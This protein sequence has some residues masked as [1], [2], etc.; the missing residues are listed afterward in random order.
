LG[1]NPVYSF[2]S[3]PLQ[4]TYIGNPGKEISAALKLKKE[5]L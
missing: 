4:N 2:S 5:K 1:L 3:K